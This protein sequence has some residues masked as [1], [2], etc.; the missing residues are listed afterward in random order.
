MRHADGY[1]VSGSPGVVSGSAVSASLGY[2]LE[3]YIFFHHGPSE[4][5]LWM[6]VRQF[7]FLKVRHGTLMQ[8]KSVRI[9]GV[10]ESFRSI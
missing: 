4:S 6:G 2:L 10:Q 8:A 9:T 5:V 3:M 7:M 1:F